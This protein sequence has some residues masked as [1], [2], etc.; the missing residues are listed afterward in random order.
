MKTP[1]RILIAV[2][3]I[4][5][6]LPLLAW[7]GT[8]LYWH[9]RITN[10]IRVIEKSP[11]NLSGRGREKELEDASS[12][13]ASAGCR[14]LPYVIDSIDPSKQPDFVEEMIF[15]MTSLLRP[16]LE[17]PNDDIYANTEFLRKCTLREQDT[18]DLRALKCNR[19][20][21]WWAD[22]RLSYH[23]WWRVCSSRCR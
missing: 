11:S 21:A 8:F 16:D 19:L 7:T 14:N 17:D 5:I 15:Q 3:S 18:S 9:F 6:F 23:Q 22:R 4:A 1:V 2:L 10:A 13:L 12:N 20:H